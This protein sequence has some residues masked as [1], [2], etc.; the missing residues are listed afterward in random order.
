M[1]DQRYQL[2]FSQAFEVFEF[3]SEGSKGSINKIVK[4][5]E[6]STQGIYNLGFGDKIDDTDDFDDNVISNNED[7]GRVLATVAG[8]V[9]IFTDKF[10]NAYVYATGSSPSRTRLYKMGISKHLEEIEE[11]FQVFGFINDSLEKFRKNRN[12]HAFLLTRK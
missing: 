7:S 11:D 9:Y 8:T 10:P 3:T 5:T 1:R 2:K 6:T 12:Y 4:Y